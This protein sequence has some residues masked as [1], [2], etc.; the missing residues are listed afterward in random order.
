MYGINSGK[1]FL[2]LKNKKVVF[3]VLLVLALLSICSCGNNK[4]VQKELDSLLDGDW[5]VVYPEDSIWTIYGS[6][7]FDIQN[8]RYH[9]YNGCNH[10]SGDYYYRGKYIIFRDAPSTLMFCP[11]SGIYGVPAADE[12]VSVDK[13]KF[14]ES[15]SVRMRINTTIPYGCDL[16]RKGK[17]MLEGLWTVKNV[18]SDETEEFTLNFDTKSNIVYLQKC[19]SKVAI[20][21]VYGNEPELSFLMNDISNEAID[22]IYPGIKSLL[23]S[24][25]G[26]SAVPRD[27]G[28]SVGIELKDEDRKIICFLERTFNGRLRDGAN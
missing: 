6:L 7:A 27:G 23:E 16:R 20:P 8:H 17:W 22:A 9:T 15:Y 24:V 26:F 14:E 10:M 18:D 13:V 2:N 19:N 25:V 12:P 5:F 11:N 3:N 4:K 28:G 1:A 21:F